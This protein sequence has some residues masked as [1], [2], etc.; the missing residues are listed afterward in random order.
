MPRP[1]QPVPDALPF[2]VRSATVDAPDARYGVAWV[3]YDATSRTV[4]VLNQGAD[5]VGRYVLDDDPTV[6]R[7][8]GTFSSFLGIVDGM[9]FVVSPDPRCT[10]HGTFKEIKHA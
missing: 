2:S 4:R 5:E 1:D 7:V 6:E 8:N 10:C 3:T 9:P